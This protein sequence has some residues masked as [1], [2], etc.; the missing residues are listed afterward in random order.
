MTKSSFSCLAI[1]SFFTNRGD[2]AAVG[3]F[4]RRGAP[5]HMCFSANLKKNL[6]T[7]WQLCYH[8]NVTMETR[9]PDNKLQSYFLKI[10]RESFWQLGIYD[11]TVAGYVADV[12][13]EFEA[14]AACHIDIANEPVAHLLHSFPRSGAGASGRRTSSAA[15]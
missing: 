15:P 9:G 10:V 8:L 11:A 3:K 13:A 6:F 4:T 14:N 5:I 1:Q 7:P 2:I 12:L